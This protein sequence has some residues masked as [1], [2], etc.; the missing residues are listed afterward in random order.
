MKALI[1]HDHTN[2][3]LGFPDKFMFCTWMARGRSR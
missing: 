3:I 2:I 1:I